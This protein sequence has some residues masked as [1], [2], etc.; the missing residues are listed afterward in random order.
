MLSVNNKLYSFDRETYEKVGLCGIHSGD[1][2]KYFCASGTT[3]TGIIYHLRERYNP[4]IILPILLAIDTGRKIKLDGFDI[5][6]MIYIYH[7]SKQVKSNLGNSIRSTVKKEILKMIPNSYP[8]SDIIRLAVNKKYIPNSVYEDYLEINRLLADQGIGIA[9]LIDISGCAAVVEANNFP[10][11]KFVSMKNYQETNYVYDISEINYSDVVYTSYFCQNCKSTSVHIDHI[12][13]KCR[14]CLPF[15]TNCKCSA[16][17]FCIME[18][19]D[20]P[21]EDA[22]CP[23]TSSLIVDPFTTKCGHVFEKESIMKWLNV[24]NTCPTCRAPQ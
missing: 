19:F 11:I 13:T 20:D 12:K 21:K 18:G 16:C 14:H 5:N 15:T 17:R 7:F 1:A 2:H 6:D 4:N 8:V 10:P 9:I 24:N 3:N 22:I 23:I